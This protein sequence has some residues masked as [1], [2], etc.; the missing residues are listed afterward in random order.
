[1]YFFL[2]IFQRFIDFYLRNCLRKCFDDHLISAVGD[3]L[4]TT[5]LFTAETL[6]SRVLLTGS[7]WL[8]IAGIAFLLLDFSHLW[9]TPAQLYCGRDVDEAATD[10]PTPIARQLFWRRMLPLNEISCYPHRGT[11]TNTR[12]RTKETIAMCQP[13]TKDGVPSETAVR[14]STFIPVFC[15]WNILVINKHLL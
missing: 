14:I 4:A 8:L 12:V 1:M 5:C 10:I 6:G 13:I 9:G 3:L 15:R 2:I 7:S 11:L